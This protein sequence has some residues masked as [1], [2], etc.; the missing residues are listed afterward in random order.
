MGLD[1]GERTAVAAR[2][3]VSRRSVLASA[4]LAIASAQADNTGVTKPRVLKEGDTVGLITPASAVT[5]PEKLAAAERT[6]R[7]FKLKPKWGKHVG[8]RAGYLGGSIE[9]RVEDLHAMFADPDVKAV[10]CVRG[11]YGSAQLLDRIDYGLIRK[12]P[13]VFIGY[14]DITAMHLAIHKK[15]GLVTFHGPVPLSAFTTFTQG[16]YRSALFEARPIGELTN[17]AE[18]NHLRPNHVIR[19]VRPGKAR[20]RLIGG[21]LSLVAATM[22]TPFEIDTRGKILF[23]ED[24]EEQPYAID[25]M[26]TQLRLAG[27]LDQAAGIVFG[28]CSSCT[29][30]DYQPSF[31]DGTFSTAEVVDRILGQLRVPV[32]SGLTIGHTADQLTLPVG[33]MAELDATKG[34]LTLTEAAT[35]G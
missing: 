29:P 2:K 5:D 19:A 31:I 27:K 23:I 8:K 22:G 16:A 13:K 33:V 18:V 24:V 15:T 1:K 9:E 11:G 28:E 25:R 7:Y 10:F 20:G 4:G 30:R 34:T 21:N 26:L 12:N 3:N 14:S 6:V 17:P 35:T 32:L